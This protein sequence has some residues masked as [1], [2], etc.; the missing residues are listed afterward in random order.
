MISRLCEIEGNR[1]ERYVF[2]LRADGT[3]YRQEFQARVPTEQRQSMAQEK[4]K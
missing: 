2:H 3:M 4:T 1:R